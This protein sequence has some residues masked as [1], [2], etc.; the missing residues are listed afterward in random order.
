MGFSPVTRKKKVAN[1]QSQEE[2]LTLNP[3][4][5]DANY[6]WKGVGM[7]SQEALN[8]GICLPILGSPINA[9]LVGDTSGCLLTLTCLNSVS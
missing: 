9:I 4:I 1:H 8:I 2:I 7:F 5:R 6:K 3:L